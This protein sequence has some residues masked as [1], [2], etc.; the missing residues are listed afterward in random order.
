M[1][2]RSSAEIF[3]M[4]FEYLAE[5]PD[6]RAKKMAK[7]MLEASANYDFSAYQMYCDEALIKL[8]LAKKNGTDEYGNECIVYEREF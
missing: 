1:S 4:V 7:K 2:D 6:E 8:G 5:I 3:G